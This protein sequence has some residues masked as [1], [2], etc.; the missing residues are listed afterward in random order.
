MTRVLIRRK[1][2]PDGH[3]KME[4]N[5]KAQKEMPCE[6]RGRGW[7]SATTNI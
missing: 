3:M 2:R 5:I 7:G 4:N 6:N 1:K